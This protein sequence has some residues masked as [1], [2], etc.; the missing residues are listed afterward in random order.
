MKFIIRLDDLPPSV[1][2][3]HRYGAKRVFLSKKT[4]EFR[5]NV[6]SAWQSAQQ[7]P[8]VGRLGFRYKTCARTRRRHYLDNVLKSIW[9]RTPIKSG[10]SATQKRAFN[11]KALSL[12]SDVSKSNI[13]SI[14]FPS[15]P[16]IFHSIAFSGPVSTSGK[17]L[18]NL[19]VWSLRTGAMSRNLY[20][21]GS[22]WPSLSRFIFL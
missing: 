16:I 4:I 12:D 11:P 17:R 14:L 1:N 21:S 7:E 2:M 6:R 18:Q 9:E 15:L 8:L 5:K 10:L 22:G 19:K 13:P 3:S 20:A